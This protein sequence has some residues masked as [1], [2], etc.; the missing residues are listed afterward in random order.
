MVY[1]GG[2]EMGKG[3]LYSYD[4][5]ESTYAKKKKPTKKRKIQNDKVRG[6]LQ[7]TYKAVMQGR[8]F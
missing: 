1:G 6:E 8:W 5:G 2:F 7:A 3:P 4:S